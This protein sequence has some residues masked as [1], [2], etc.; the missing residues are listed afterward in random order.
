M[1]GC[2]PAGEPS[3][4]IRYQRAFARTEFCKLSKGTTNDS[5]QQEHTEECAPPSIMELCSPVVLL[6]IFFHSTE[7]LSTADDGG[8]QHVCE[9][10]PKM[11]WRMYSTAK[12]Q[13]CGISRTQEIHFPA[14][15]RGPYLCVNHELDT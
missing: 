11:F 14:K 13:P 12:S 6:N 5:K 1:G 3:P 7:Q 15:Q 4:Q 8:I 10:G 9:L 2:C